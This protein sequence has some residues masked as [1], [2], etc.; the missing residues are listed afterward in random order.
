MKNKL[1]FSLSPE[2]LSQAQKELAKMV[3][4]NKVIIEKSKPEPKPKPKP[5][6]D[7]RHIL[8]KYSTLFYLVSTLVSHVA[9][10]VEKDGVSKVAKKLG[11]SK[12]NLRTMLNGTMFSVK[13]MNRLLLHYGYEIKLYKIN[14]HD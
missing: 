13:T 2:V 6:R 12:T 10:D 1:P 9:Q 5:V 11:I 4:S 7:Y 3:A 8:D 14:N